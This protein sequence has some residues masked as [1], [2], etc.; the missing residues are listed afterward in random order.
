MDNSEK[1]DNIFDFDFCSI[2]SI[3]GYIALIIS[4]LITFIP[5]NKLNWFEMGMGKYIGV[6]S[7]FAVY[8]LMIKNYFS[9]FF[10]SLFSF[11]FSVHELIIFYDN[12][13]IELGKELGD[14]GLYRS[15]PEIFLEVANV[16]YGVFWAI[17]GSLLSLVFVSIGWIKNTVKDNHS[18]AI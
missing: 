2:I 14:T 9:A 5:I 7:I 1:K 17:V 4:A 18:V 13:A 6:A 15:I 12:Y 11:F 3:I 10:I 8:L 16:K